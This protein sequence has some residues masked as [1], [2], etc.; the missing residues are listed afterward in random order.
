MLLNKARE[1]VLSVV[2]EYGVFQ[3]LMTGFG[4]TKYK[5]IGM[6]QHPV[7]PGIPKCYRIQVFF[8]ERKFTAS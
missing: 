3:F 1:E 7:V 2:V 8:A 4:L 5:Y 6:Q